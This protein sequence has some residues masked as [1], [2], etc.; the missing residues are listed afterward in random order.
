MR[1]YIRGWSI[2]RRLWRCLSAQSKN[3][4]RCTVKTIDTR[5]Y[6]GHKC[7]VQYRTFRSGTSGALGGGG[8]PGIEQ[9]VLNDLKRT[10]LS[11]S[12]MIRLLAHPLPPS[13]VS[14]LFLLLILPCMSP[15]EL[16]DG[17][18][19]GGVGAKSYDGEK[20]WSPINHSILSGIE[21]GGAVVYL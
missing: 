19:V 13:P 2:K 12:Q 18:G 20:T 1:R 7:I 8:G 11:C 3:I 9:R 6:A 21:G 14:K 10:R 4:Y 5:M 16:T 17:R 15:V